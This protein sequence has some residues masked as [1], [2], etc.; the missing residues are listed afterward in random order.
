MINVP[1]KLIP[2][3]DTSYDTKIIYGGRSS[4]KTATIIRY[5]IVRAMK[6]KLLI[7]CCREFQSSIERSTYAELRAFIYEFNLFDFFTI[8]HDKIVGVNGSEFL[9]VG[10]SPL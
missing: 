5:L 10:L 3:F 2:I 1:K 7:L 4:A 6:E 8:K 9:F